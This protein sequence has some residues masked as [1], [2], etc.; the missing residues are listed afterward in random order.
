M[1]I[2]YG[3]SATTADVCSKKKNIS[4][5]DW[6]H[7]GTEAFLKNPSAFLLHVIVNFKVSRN[8]RAAWTRRSSKWDSTLASPNVSECGFMMRASDWTTS[9]QKRDLA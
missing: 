7:Q 5:E 2:A 6:F 4:L 1:C 8:R 9:L 3:R